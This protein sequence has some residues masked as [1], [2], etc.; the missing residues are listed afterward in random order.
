MSLDVIAKTWSELAPLKLQP[1]L[2]IWHPIPPNAKDI[3]GVFAEVLLSLKTAFRRIGADVP[4]I[5]SPRPL[6]DNAIIVSGLLIE[7]I[8]RAVRRPALSLPKNAIVYN[9]E[10]IYDGAKV[11]SKDY[12]A[13]LRG[14]EVWDYSVENIAALHKIGIEA[15]HVPVGY[16]PD[17]ECYKPKDKQDIDVLFVGAGNDRR[18]AILNSIRDAGLNVVHA[19]GVYGRERDEL[20][21]RS[22][23][24]LNIHYYPAMVFETVRV[25]YLL[26]NGSLVISEDGLDTESENEYK[27]GVVFGK[28][29]ELPALC[30]QYA[31]DPEARARVA[32]Q[33]RR[34]MRSMKFENFV[35]KALRQP[36]CRA[37]LR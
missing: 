4:V 14:S 36:G 26:A 18:H 9:H 3:N 8:R 32:A 27:G 34:I 25:S 5:K 37:A 12:E 16:V 33:G 17:L 20:C 23:I 21:S 7:S 31:K 29:N 6:N 30:A 11:L 35:E 13:L 19:T 10:Q 24:V 1:D 22:K 15:K 28:V 2:H